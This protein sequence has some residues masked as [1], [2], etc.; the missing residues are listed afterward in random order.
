MNATLAHW[1]VSHTFTG[2]PGGHCL[3]TSMWS[4]AS[5]DGPIVRRDVD[6]FS[7]WARRRQ[8]LGAPGVAGLDAEAAAEEVGREIAGKGLDEFI[9]MGQSR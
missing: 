7:F 1:I 3:T 6:C 4:S 2:R 8:A 9:R 5:K